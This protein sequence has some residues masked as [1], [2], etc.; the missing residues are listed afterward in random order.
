MS[1]AI[2]EDR[3]KAAMRNLA[4]GVTLITS[5]SADE[6]GGMTATAVCSLT[7]EPPQVLVCV[8][9]SAATHRMIAEN[10]KFCVNV[11]TQDQQGVAS[12]FASK[13]GWQERFASGEWT[14]L[15]TG[16]PVLVDAL[17]SFDCVLVDAIESGTHSIFVGRVVDVC[18]ADPVSPLL[19]YQSQ[20]AGIAA[21]AA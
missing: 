3:F 21:C 8:N 16:A 9:R 4:S 5:A 13:S 12:T 19:Y 1:E 18:E 6:R 20:F 15:S 17:A 14:T 11:L 7:A 2:S 10:G